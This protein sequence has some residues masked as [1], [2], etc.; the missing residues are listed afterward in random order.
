[1]AFLLLYNTTESIA[2]KMRGY[3]N[4]GLQVKKVTV[5]Q[6]GEPPK[7]FVQLSQLEA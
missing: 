4:S 3:I 6:Q 7:K 1:M 5:E 2:F